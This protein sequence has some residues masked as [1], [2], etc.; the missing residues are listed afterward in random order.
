M[1][2]SIASARCEVQRVVEESF[3]SLRK[4]RVRVLLRAMQEVKKQTRVWM[5]VAGRRLAKWK[6]GNSSSLLA[7]VA[8][9]SGSGTLSRP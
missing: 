7:D 4:Y 3:T 6:A 1:E 9:A 5:G 2:E 8:K